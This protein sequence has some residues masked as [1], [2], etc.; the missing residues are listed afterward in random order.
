MPV[1]SRTALR[2][3]GAAASAA[4]ARRAALE[5]LGGQSGVDGQRRPLDPLLQLL[6]DAGDQQ[7]RAGVEQHDVAP[8]A[9]A[10]RAG[11]ASIIRAF[12]VGRAAGQ[13]AVAAR[14]KPERGGVDDVAL[15]RVAGDDVQRRRCRRAAARRRRRR[16]S[17]TS[18][19]CR[20]GGRPRPSA[21][22][23]AASP[24]P[25]SCRVVPAGL[26]SGPSRLNAVRTPI[27]RRVG[28]ACFIAGWKFGANRNAKPSVAQRRAG[29]RGVVVDPDA[30]RIE[31]VGRARPAR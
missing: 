21:A 9:R 6:D 29:R 22:A 5:E 1:R 10:R 15:D 14:L 31:D 8:A 18:A 27:S 3:L 7:R 17:R 24:T 13:L 16:G 2:R 20:A 4:V 23:T 12:S 25:S 11:S 28:P 19:R 26:V 30:E